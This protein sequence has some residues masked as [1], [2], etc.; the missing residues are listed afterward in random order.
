MIIHWHTFNLTCL[1]APIIKIYTT[2]EPPLNFSI[3]SSKES[4]AGAQV[5]G[6][7]TDI[8]REILILT[9]NTTAPIVLLPWARAYQ[10]TLHGENV[11]LFSMGRTKQR[12][13]LFQWIGPLAEKK[14]VL[15]STQQAQITINS[16][17]DAKAV[18]NIATVIDD[19]K[20]QFLKSQGF[21]NLSSSPR[22]SQA[23]QKLFINRAALLVQTDL[24]IP[25][26]IREA[27]YSIDAIKPVYELYKFQ[28]F[29]G[30]SQKTSP[31]L[32][33]R[34]QLA[35]G[36]LKKNGRFKALIKKWANHYQLTN[37]RYQNGMLQ[38]IY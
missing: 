2:E 22:W 26:I 11:F 1:A 20:E 12:E 24:D 6:F 28:L 27:G 15:Y 29:I 37:W 4:A 31:Q 10:Y 19:S 9:D 21:T 25:F 8:V 38:V 5:S 33:K 17:D 3:G 18:S 32:V 35:L 30:T 36:T 34:W 13:Q 23:V 7:A 14:A 16:L